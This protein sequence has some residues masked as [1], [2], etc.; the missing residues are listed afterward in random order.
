MVACVSEGG[1]IYG[2]SSSQ[3]VESPS[4][5]IRYSGCLHII[6]SVLSI[7]NSEFERYSKWS[8]SSSVY[9]IRHLPSGISQFLNEIKLD[10]RVTVS[11]SV[12]GCCTS[13]E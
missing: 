11:R 9:I 4:Y 13:D 3:A 5:Q 7:A 6:R 8:V 12:Q 10:L 2:R 1:K